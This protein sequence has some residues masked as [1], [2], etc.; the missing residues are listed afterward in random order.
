MVGAG[1]A[2]AAGVGVAVGVADGAR[3]GLELAA[4]EVV[5]L[6]GGLEVGDGAAVIVGER[7]A[8]DDG[9]D[10]CSE[11]ETH[12]PRNRASVMAISVRDSLI[13]TTISVDP[14]RLA[15]EYMLW[16]VS[17]ARDEPPAPHRVGRRLE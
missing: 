4:G 5:G 13:C 15:R 7:D 12:A 16:P 17:T 11:T 1:V 6:A 8:F 2:D 3:V 9:S 10:V 14:P